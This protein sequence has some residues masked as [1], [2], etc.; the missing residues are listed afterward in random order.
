MSCIAAVPRQYLPAADIPVARR[1]SHSER[2]AT[3]LSKT[4][5]TFRQEIDYMEEFVWQPYEEVTIPNELDGHLE[6][7]DTVVLLLSFEC[8]AWHPM[9]RVMLQ[10]GYAQPA[11]EIARDILLEEHCM[12]L[13]G[14]SFT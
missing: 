5:A 4:T 7:C 9:N 12:T 11:T 10:F 2:T 14:E 3:W 13:C 1:W 8:V 6:M